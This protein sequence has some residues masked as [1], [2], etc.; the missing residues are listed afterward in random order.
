M[1]GKLEAMLGSANGSGINAMYVIMSFDL[2]QYRYPS[3][4]CNHDFAV[5]GVQQRVVSLRLT[6][7]TYCP[8]Q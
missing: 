2:L 8:G 1:T 6:R 3:V 5:T 7:L 4:R